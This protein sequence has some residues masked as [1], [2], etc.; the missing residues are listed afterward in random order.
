VSNKE[1][2]MEYAKRRLKEKECKK[3]VLENDITGL[4]IR[5]IE[6]TTRRKIG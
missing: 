4:S 5:A 6:K 1:N 2:F 3:R